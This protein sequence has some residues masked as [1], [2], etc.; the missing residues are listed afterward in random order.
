MNSCI[1]VVP[2]GGMSCHSCWTLFH[3]L[4][5]GRVNICVS[6]IVF[7]ITLIT[8]LAVLLVRRGVDVI[9]DVIVGPVLSLKGRVPVSVLDVDAPGIMA[10]NKMHAVDDVLWEG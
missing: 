6:V 10:G 3:F 5:R 7:F 9:V 4:V 1:P 8:V 2:T